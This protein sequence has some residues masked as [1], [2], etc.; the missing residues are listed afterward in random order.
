MD[1]ETPV[2]KR[3]QSGKG[4]V[5]FFRSLHQRCH[6][7]FLH[8]YMWNIKFQC[9][10][11]KQLKTRTKKNIQEKNNLA[12]DSLHLF[13]HGVAKGIDC[14]I[15]RSERGRGGAKSQDSKTVKYKQTLVQHVYSEGVKRHALL[16]IHTYTFPFS[17]S[18]VHK[19]D[20]W[21]FR[22]RND[23]FAAAAGQQYFD[24]F[25]LVHSRALLYQWRR[26]PFCCVY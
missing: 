4:T 3:R 19:R 1:E 20:A 5:I 2:K 26:F 14:H 23:H 8:G 16:S 18:S 22:M 7:F 6:R 9:T 21:T 15:L 10:R 11:P 13:F 17:L 24:V 25:V 12:E